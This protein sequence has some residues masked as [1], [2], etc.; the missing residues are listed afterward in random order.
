MNRVVFLVLHLEGDLCPD[1]DILSHI[2]LFSYKI[3]SQWLHIC[4]I[5]SL[6]QCSRKKFP[7]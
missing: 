3:D 2:L 6:L 4:A 1:P 5:F 7:T